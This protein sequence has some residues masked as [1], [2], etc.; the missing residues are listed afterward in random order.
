VFNTASGNCL[1]GLYMHGAFT[2]G[3]KDRAKT[4]PQRVC[5]CSEM[6]LMLLCSCSKIFC[7]L[8]KKSSEVYLVPWD[9]RAKADF[10]AMLIGKF[11]RLPLL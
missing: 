5:H 11:P 3:E 6:T 10:R 9:F 4:E 8:S 1:L 2:L 7:L